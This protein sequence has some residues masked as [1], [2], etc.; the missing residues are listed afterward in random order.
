MEVPQENTLYSYLKQKC[1][2]FFLFLFSY[3][4]SENRRAEQ[5]LSRGIGTGRRGRR[6]GNDEGR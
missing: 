2:F 4:K 5:V 6:W 3:T 1:H